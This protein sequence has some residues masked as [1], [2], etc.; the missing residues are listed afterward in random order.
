MPSRDHSAWVAHL[1]W[2]GEDHAAFCFYLVQKNA[3]GVRRSIGRRSG[4]FCGDQQQ[5]RIDGIYAN[6]VGGGNPKRISV[7]IFQ[8]Q[9]LLRAIIA[10]P[11][12]A[13]RV[14]G[15]KCVRIDPAVKR[16]DDSRVE[17][18]GIFGSAGR[19]GPH[20]PF[21]IL[22][23]KECDAVV[24]ERPERLA[25]GAVDQIFGAARVEIVENNGAFGAHLGIVSREEEFFTVVRERELGAGSRNGGGNDFFCGATAHDNFPGGIYECDGRGNFEIGDGGDGRFFLV[26]VIVVVFAL[27]HD[28]GEEFSGDTGATAKRA[29]LSVFQNDAEGIFYRSRRGR[30]RSRLTWQRLRRI[31]RSCWGATARPRKP[32]ASNEW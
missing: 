7:D 27:I 4:V 14:G 9:S 24:I 11:I 6:G 10:N 8:R 15:E 13:L 21:L 23:L 20:L 17:R 2:R 29:D 28:F 22:R 3:R 31:F 18:F 1:V 25:D 5:I 26:G 30:G 19:E 12:N 16:I 32:L